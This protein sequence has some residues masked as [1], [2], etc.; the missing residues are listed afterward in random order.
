VLA[1]ARSSRVPCRSSIPQNVRFCSLAPV[2]L[3]DETN[4]LRER[5]GTGKA[6]SE[7]E[8]STGDDDNEAAP[9]P[10]HPPVFVPLPAP[11]TNFAN[12]GGFQQSVCCGAL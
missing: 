6:V 5:T 1:D 8:I 9:V 12:F 7:F 10:S 4:F 11:R 3:P 2:C